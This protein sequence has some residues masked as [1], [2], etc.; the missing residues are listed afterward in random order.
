MSQRIVVLGAGGF[1]GRR[2]VAA[3]AASDWAT[4][5]ATSRHAIT[6]LPEGT[7]QRRVDATSEA[8][9][10]RALD[11][12]IGIVNCVAGSAET[13]VAGA[14]ALFAA[15]ARMAPLPRVVNLSSLSAYGSAT[16]W[17]DESTPLLGDLG[18]YSAA[19]AEAERLATASAPVVHLRPGI[20]YGPGSPL[21]SGLIGRLL[22][23][24]R[25]GN[26]GEAGAGYCNL[27]HVDDVAKAAL[28]ALRQP[29]IEGQ[30]F[31]LSQPAP[32]TWNEYFRLYADALG[33]P[34]LTNISPARLALELKLLGPL[35]KIVE[36]AS[37]ALKLRKEN[38]PRP[39]RPWL[40]TLCRHQIR[41]NVQRAEQAL[42]MKWTPL[43]QGLRET[44]AWFH[45]QRPE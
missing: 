29:G 22:I 5:V 20:V 1:I 10:T 12:A 14:R 40:T 8:D 13:I 44:A 18:P 26:L 19:K 30:A 37:A 9:L 25:L 36:L 45:T 32:P 24:R 11:G 6:G 3:L 33:A 4:P 39:I 28:L 34:P 35:L 23:A 17:V 21:W 27:V 16:G 31:N 42:G 41:M 15:A 43:E 2:V 7:E 38:L